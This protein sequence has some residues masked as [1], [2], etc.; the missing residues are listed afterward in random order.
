M[1]LLPNGNIEITV[2]LLPDAYAAMK[3]S[4]ERDGIREIDMVNAAICAYDQIS[5]MAAEAGTPLRDD[6]AP[7]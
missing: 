4:A 7:C 3:A 5:R 1:K 6:G 2:Q